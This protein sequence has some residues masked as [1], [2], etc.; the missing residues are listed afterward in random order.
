MSRAP[1]PKRQRQSSQSGVPDIVQLQ[2]QISMDVDSNIPVSTTIPK[3]VVKPAS[4]AYK[5]QFNQEAQQEAYNIDALSK[6]LRD[7][8]FV[9]SLI[10]AEAAFLQYKIGLYE[11]LSQVSFDS[12][13][14]ENE[15]S[16]LDR[17]IRDIIVELKTK[18]R[19][20][21]VVSK[22]DIE[23]KRSLLSNFVHDKH[24]GLASVKG[25]SRESVRSSIV[26]IIMTFEKL[27]ILYA[28]SFLNIMMT[29]PAGSGKTKISSVIAHAFHALGVLHTPVVNIVT[30]QNLVG[31]Y[32]GQ[33]APKTRAALVR[34]LEG[35]LF[36]DEAYTITPCPGK[37]NNDNSYSE[38]AIGELINFLDKFKGCI[39]VIVA[40]YRDKMY[41]CFLEFNEGINRRFPKKMDLVD[42]T[43]ADLF[44]LFLGFVDETHVSPDKL[45]SSTQKALISNWV[46]K[47]NE[48]GVFNNQAGDILNLTTAVLEDAL[49]KGKQYNE[50]AIEQSIKSFLLAK[51]LEVVYK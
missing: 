36:I 26:K 14:E 48:L 17:K 21:A 32:L 2:R 11:R 45:L 41:N 38:E 43:D 19:K 22:A 18:Y 5:L 16:S 35:V 44:D 34:S 42:Y 49:I 9:R 6:K 23:T 39:V 20:I 8:A 33:S 31:E 25:E 13:S 24:D 15:Q 47:L 29:G 28:T 3:F 1:Q 7:D 27:P 51:D 30:K 37:S 50:A 40:G 10:E 12:S 4:S 46:R